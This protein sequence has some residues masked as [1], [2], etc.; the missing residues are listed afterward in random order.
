MFKTYLAEIGGTF[1]L[2]SVIFRSLRQPETR[3]I[4]PFAIG[5]ALTIA[6]LLFYHVSEGHFNPAVTFAVWMNSKMKTPEA[7]SYVLSQLVGAWL[8][9][10]WLQYTH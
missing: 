10:V 4:A 7:A 6:I 1:L 2:L 9:V 5:L 8:A 3:M